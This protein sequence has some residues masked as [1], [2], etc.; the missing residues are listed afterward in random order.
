[1]ASI[2]AKGP[3]VF[4]SEEA[5]VLA[6]RKALEFAMDAGFSALVI[7][8]DNAIVMNYL[9]NSRAAQSRLGHLYGDIQC[10]A[11]GLHALSVNCVTRSAN[12]VAHSLARFARCITDEVVW[13][14]E[15]PPPTLEALYFDS[16]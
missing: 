1:M 8:S 5:E 6:C 15:S 13:V 7:E 12:S 14:E 2:S 16:H 10:M 11:A 9:F 3:P 4:D